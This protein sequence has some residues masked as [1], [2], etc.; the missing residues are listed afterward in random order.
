MCV[1]CVRK[2]VFLAILLGKS[3]Q[4]SR[5][6]RVLEEDVLAAVHVQRQGAAGRLAQASREG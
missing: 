6:E 2:C 1:V 3:L 4:L 5:V